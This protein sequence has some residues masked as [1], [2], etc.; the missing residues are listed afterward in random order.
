MLQLDVTVWAICAPMPSASEVRERGGSGCAGAY[1]C[2]GAERQAL[3]GK[4]ADLTVGL[5]LP[6]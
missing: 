5:R 6:G 4:P 3:E 2:P 1:L